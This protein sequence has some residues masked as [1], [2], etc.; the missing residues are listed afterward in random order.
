MV[1]RLESLLQIAPDFGAIVLDQWG[2]LH[3][4]TD[5][6]PSAIDTVKELKSAGHRLAVLS[7]SGKRAAPNTDRIAAIG[8]DVSAF[9]IVI[10]SG[11]ALWQDIST[12]R[13]QERNLYAIERGVG[14]AEKW[15]QGLDIRLTKSVDQ[16]DALLLMGLPD[17]SARPDYVEVTQAALSRR[18]RVFCTNPDRASPRAGGRVVVSPGALAHDYAQ[19][20][21]EV[22]YYGKP[23]TPVFR[24]LELALDLPPQRLL[25]VGDSLEHDV[26]GGHAAGWSTVFVRGGLHA[27]AFA[28]PTPPVCEVIA[29]LAA[30][31]AAPMPDFTLAQ[32]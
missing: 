15:A 20:G 11:E 26:A 13:V 14:D 10:S 7:N 9:E 23:H 32:L 12:G 3:D 17:D 24:S 22:V 28:Q 31:E 6:Y 4:G 21:G 2:V 8:F 1:E 19:A 25:M 27:R 29:S 5:A 16:A 30:Q 18:L